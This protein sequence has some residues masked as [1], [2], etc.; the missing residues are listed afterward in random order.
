MPDSKANPEDP[1]S[2]DHRSKDPSAKDPSSKDPSAGPAGHGVA[3]QGPAGQGTAG[4]GAGARREDT[5]SFG[6]A[7]IPAAEKA[8]RV[9]QVFDSVAGRYDLMNDLMSAGVHRLWKA[10]LLDWLAPRPGARLLDVA[11][12]TGDIARGFLR[13]TKAKGGAEAIVCDIN[14]EMLQAGRTRPDGA[15]LRWLCGNA[16]AVPLP[17]AAVDAY[18]IGFGIRNVTHLD[19]ALAEAH[20]V[21]RPGGRFL[22]LE[23]SQPVLPLLDRLYDAYSFNVIP[24][25]GALVTN[26]RGSYAYLVESIRRFPTQRGFAQRI[27]GAGFSRVSY[28][29]LSGGIA[30]LHSGWRL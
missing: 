12:G 15:G 26:D 20:R 10:A 16:E 1:R 8:P 21:L 27:A 4:Q 23:F 6:F 14:Y 24:R 5:A 9:R 28:R 17:D 3:G 2:K 30:A 22:C 7:D 19:A 29:N 25:L 13:R 11:G 18:T